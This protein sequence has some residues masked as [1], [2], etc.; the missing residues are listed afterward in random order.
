MQSVEEHPKVQMLKAK[1]IWNIKRPEGW[2][3]VGIKT[4]CNSFVH[5]TFVCTTK[6]YTFCSNQP[7]PHTGKAEAVLQGEG[8]SLP[9]AQDMAFLDTHQYTAEAG[10]AYFL[11]QNQ[12]PGRV[13][14]LQPCT[15]PACRMTAQEDAK[16]GNLP[17]PH[18]RC[19]VCTAVAYDRPANTL[20]A[21][22]VCVYQRWSSPRTKTMP[23]R[24]TR[25][26]QQQ[27]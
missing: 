12:A 2:S 22:L 14:F 5:I 4:S 21:V 17:G 3:C 1:M 13:H 11:L 6:I 15:L 19:T 7:Q 27:R 10:A 20:C 25:Q 18:I 26:V 9:S 23:S 16:T 24:A 8:R